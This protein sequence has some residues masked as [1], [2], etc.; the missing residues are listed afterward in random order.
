MTTRFSW[1]ATSFFLIVALA[2]AINAIHAQRNE[3]VGGKIYYPAGRKGSL[4]PQ[5]CAGACANRCSATSHEKPCLF[6]CNK[7]CQKCLCVPRGT[8]G[9]KEECPC[10]DNWKTKRGT[11]K[12]P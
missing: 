8:S 6:F 3:N 10:Y 1:I 2:M 5:D 4:R 11:P 9:H 7:C 12:C